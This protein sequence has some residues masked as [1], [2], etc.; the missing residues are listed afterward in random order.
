MT[1]ISPTLPSIAFS[2]WRPWKEGS[3]Q[4]ESFLDYTRDVTLAKYQADTVGQYISQAS[5]EQIQA[6]GELGDKISLASY[7]QVQAI[8][9]ASYE[10]VSAIENAAHQQVRAL[11]ELGQKIEKG[12]FYLTY[13]MSEMNQ[14][15]S[16]LKKNL[17]IQ[18][19]QQKVTNLLLED[20]RE[21]LRVPNSEKERQHSIELGLKFFVNAAKDDDLFAD[22]LEELLEAEKLMKQDYFVLHR[23]GLIY[24]YSKKHVNPQTA[25]DYF[26][27]A[28]KYAS[29]ESDPKAARLAN[30]L[31]L[32]GNS[33]VNTEIASDINAIELL[34][35]E[36]YEKAAFAAY[37][38]GNFELAV[39]HQ[40]KALKFN[41]NAENKF[42][43]AKYL[44]RLKQIDLCVQNLNK[45]IDEKPSIFYAVFK[46]L[47]LVNE[48][49]V[50]RL[51]EEK[52]DDINKKIQHLTNEWATVQSTSA[53]EVIIE[54][55]KLSIKSYEVKVEQFPV[56]STF[57]TDLEKEIEN[58]KNDVLELI[59]KFKNTILLLEDVIVEKIIH[60]LDFCLDKP[61]EVIKEVY[62][63]KSLMFIPLEIDSKYAGGIVFYIDK[64]GKHGLVVAPN[65]Q[66]RAVQWDK[67]RFMTTGATGTKIGDGMANTKKIIDSQGDYTYAAKLCADLI[68]D[69]FQDWFLP[70][71]DEL[72]L[73]SKRSISLK[74]F[75]FEGI[76]WSST[77]D[78]NPD[79][80]WCVF[81]SNNS[82]PTFT[83]RQL[84]EKNR[85]IKNPYV[86][87][88]RAIR[89]F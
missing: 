85:V 75:N 21:L 59:D 55:K 68:I 76:Y 61:F 71:I 52:N 3:N 63:Q 84:L 73:L 15:L 20:I 29:V 42:F 28:A 83:E 13:Q 56:F 66:S 81:I 46:D 12:F 4:F 19:E 32:F 10:Q 8:E 77:E 24:M 31:T 2:Y 35:A 27:K 9:Q 44:T 82:N 37:V 18:I 40:R 7:E 89:S 86:Y 14:Q 38:L 1:N 41:N 72:E 87:A 53:Q 88:V 16:F 6:I 49:E 64:S 22:A 5:S 34:A 43:L 62:A 11:G 80:V 74:L 70:S 36:S 69:G 30:V 58:L 17:D 23:I 33:R 57:K 51:I 78:Y 25:L 79:K 48:P 60:D 47:D 54:L 50:L 26:T 45:S 65:D 39:M 67:A